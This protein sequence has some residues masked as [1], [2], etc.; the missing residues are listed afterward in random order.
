M[1][2]AVMAAVEESI[3]GYRVQLADMQTAL[4]TLDATYAQQKALG[5]KTVD[6]CDGAI[7]ALEQLKLD[8][9]AKN[10]PPTDA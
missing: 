6:M 1:M 9:Q 7:Q 8:L 10:E 3:T 2:D 4:Q 5:Q